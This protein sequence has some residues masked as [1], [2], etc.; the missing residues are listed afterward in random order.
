MGGIDVNAV[1]QQV[2]FFLAAGLIYACYGL[3]GFILESVYV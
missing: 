3:S 2:Q 1:P